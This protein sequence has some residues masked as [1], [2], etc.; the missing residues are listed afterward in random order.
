MRCP[1]CGNEVDKLI[2]GFY[3]KYCYE[4][5]PEVDSPFGAF[6]NDWGDGSDGS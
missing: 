6:Y 5:L 2:E 3:C 1:N 4:T